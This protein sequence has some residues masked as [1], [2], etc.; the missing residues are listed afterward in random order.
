MLIPQ[1]RTYLQHGLKATPI[2]IS[3]MIANADKINYDLRPYADRFT[4]REM[5]CHLADWE[6]IFFTRVSRMV[7]EDNPTLPN[8]D[9]G[10]VAIDNDYAHSDAAVQ[11]ARFVTGRERF[12]NYLSE[13]PDAAW[14]RP[15]L[16][17]ELGPMTVDSMCVMIVGHDGYHTRQVAE[18]L[19]LMK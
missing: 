18:W 11:L 9:E 13:L 4:L 15:G 6:D 14:S 10:Q 7:D 3:S 12:A 1:V 19:E 5:L 2:V 8:I 16:R 17:P